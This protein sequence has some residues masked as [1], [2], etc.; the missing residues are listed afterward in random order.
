LGDT[1][2]N[3]MLHI[4]SGTHDRTIVQ[5]KKDKEESNDTTLASL[6]VQPCK[7]TSTTTQCKDSILPPR[8][9][10]THERQTTSDLLSQ[11]HQHT[12]SY[13]SVWYLQPSAK[14]ATSDTI[15]ARGQEVGVI[16]R[17]QQ[18]SGRKPR[19]HCHHSILHS[20]SSYQDTTEF[21]THFSVP[22]NSEASRHCY[23]HPR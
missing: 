22:L 15:H 23:K 9:L 2:H 19:N 7:P 8:N 21:H 17:I 16:S 5:S 14:K 20:Y 18:S 10:K 12:K 11:Q 13:Y 4:L 1:Q 3:D 6:Q